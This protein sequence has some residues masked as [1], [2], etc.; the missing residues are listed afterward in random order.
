MSSPFD[1]L[2][3]LDESLVK[4]LASLVLT[5]YIETI[6]LTQAFDRTLK[7][8]TR[9]TDRRENSSQGSITKIEHEGFKDKNELDSC[10]NFEHHQLNND[11]DAIQCVKEE[12]KIQTTYT[13][14]VLNGNLMDYLNQN[15]ELVHKDVDD[16]EN[17][18]IDSGDLIEVE[19]TITNSSILCYIDC[20]INLIDIFG[21]DYL[22]KLME[23]SECKMNFTM[24]KKML[25]HINGLLNCNNTIDL[26]MN[27]GNGTAVLTVNKDNFMNSQCNIFDKINCHCKVIGK[28]IKT[29]ADENDSISLLRK[30]GQENFYE[31]FFEKA[32]PLLECLRKNDFFVPECPD[33]RINEKAVQIM[34]INIYM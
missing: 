27:V 5:G 17:D 12:R 11:V 34:P 15:N 19:G 18:N 31:K 23:N 14:F 24:F 25:T 9:E 4:N 16:I 29:C 6:T 2:V 32:E 22:D 21:A 20:L 13:S 10:N 7:A 8:G 33:L 26:L 1:I 3:Y 28:V 30:T